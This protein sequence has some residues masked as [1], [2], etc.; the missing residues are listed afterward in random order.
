MLYLN[1]ILLRYVPY[2]FTCKF[3][4][5]CLIFYSIICTYS[6]Q[7]PSI[8]SH[9]VGLHVHVL[10]PNTEIILRVRITK[11]KTSILLKQERL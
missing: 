2:H 7:E 4:C 8:S 9:M 3:K 6:K 1:T 11:D 10:F 5:K